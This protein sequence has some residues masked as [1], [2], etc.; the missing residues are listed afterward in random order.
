M[1]RVVIS[2]VYRLKGTRPIFSEK[3]AQNYDICE[4][5]AKGPT[6]KYLV[7]AILAMRKR[8]K[9]RRYIY[10]MV[11]VKLSG[12][13]NQVSG[14]NDSFWFSADKRRKGRKMATSDLSVC[15]TQLI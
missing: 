6:T 12:Y 9:N 13:P 15:F 10:E 5:L 7:S 4:R 14:K 8:W 2:A 3:V 11:T 1:F